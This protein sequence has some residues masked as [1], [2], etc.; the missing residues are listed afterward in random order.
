MP[1]IGRKSSVNE[2][3]SETIIGLIKEGKT[4]AQIARIIGVSRN[5]IGNW[6]GKY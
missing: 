3:L 6:K 2:K 4:E 1:K 5:T